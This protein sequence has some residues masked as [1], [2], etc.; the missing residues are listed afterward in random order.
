MMRSEPLLTFSLARQRFALRA[1]SVDTVVP[2]AAIGALP[3]APGVVVGTLVVRGELLAVFDIRAALGLPIRPV[4]LAD[5]FVV[6]RM[7]SEARRVVLV[8]EGVEDLRKVP[9]SALVPSRDLVER[10]TLTAFIAKLEDGTCAIVDLDGFLSAAERDEL[11]LALGRLAGATTP[12][13]PEPE[14][15]QERGAERCSGPVPTTRATTRTATMTD[16]AD[17]RA[18]SPTAHSGR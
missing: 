15:E 11:D 14:P 18:R 12:G 3:H 8:T 13:E 9:A 7:R 16:R 2:A 5:H 6:A 10:G 17:R 1:S 4:R